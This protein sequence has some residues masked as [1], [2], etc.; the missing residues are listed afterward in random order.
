MNQTDSG[1]LDQLSTYDAVLSALGDRDRQNLAR[2]LAFCET[3]PGPEHARLWKRLVCTLAGLGPYSIQTT[4]QK[5]VRFFEADGRYRRQVFAL[6]DP[7]DGT[8]LLYLADVLDSAIRDR[9]I[10][11]PTLGDGGATTY[12]VCAAPQFSLRLDVLTAAGTV[13]APDFYRHMLGWN[14]KAI[15]ITLPTIAHEA[16][17]RAAEMLCSSSVNQPKA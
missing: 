8:L 3:E 14:R 6:E 13:S 11:R 9:L 2:H 12:G 16:Q 10:G 5:A 17:V 7:R 1:T 15:R 4:G